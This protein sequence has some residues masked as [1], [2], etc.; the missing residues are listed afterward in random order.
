MAITNILSFSIW[1]WLI[2]PPGIDETQR[3][4]EP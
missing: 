1:D 4:D 2:D 3:V